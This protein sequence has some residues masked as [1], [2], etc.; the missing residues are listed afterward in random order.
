[1]F[2]TL[3]CSIAPSS[4]TKLVAQGGALPRTSKGRLQVHRLTEDIEREEL[5]Q[6]TFPAPGIF[7]S[8]VE[9]EVPRQ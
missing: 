9:G 7:R 4:A 8:S 5:L 2:S 1:M 6:A 3:K